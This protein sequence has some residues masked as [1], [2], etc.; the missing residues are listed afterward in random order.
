MRSA[1]LLLALAVACGDDSAPGSDASTDVPGTDADGTDADGVDAPGTDAPGCGTDQE[2]ADV[3]IPMRDGAMLAAFIRR[4]VDAD[5][6][7]PTVLIQ[8]PYDKEN[9]RALW[10]ES[11]G[12]NPLFDSTDYAFVVLDWRGRFG[13]SDAEADSMKLGTDGF[14]A[15]E[16]ITAQTWSDGSVGTFG[17]SALCRVQ[18]RTA[19]EQPPGLRAAVPIF[20]PRREEYEQYFPGGVLR[21]EYL[22]S[23]GI[24]FGTVSTLLETHPTHDAL[25][26]SVENTTDPTARIQTPMLLISGWWDLSPAIQLADFA[27]LRER[28]PAGDDHRLLIGPWSHFATNAESEGI[29][30]DY[31]DEERLYFD[32]EQQIQSDTLAFFDLHLRGLE[33]AASA[34]PTVRWT[35]GASETEESGDAWPPSDSISRE[36]YL[37]SGDTL[38]TG[39]PDGPPIDV[40]F[41]CDPADPS[42]TI[43]GMGLRFDLL[44]GPTD[45]AEVIARDDAVTF[46]T[47]PVSETLR[48]RGR[49]VANLRVKTTGA[50]TDF[51]VRI[52]D[53]RPDGTWLWIGEG[54]RRLSLRDDFGTRSEVVA[55]TEYD[56]PVELANHL[57]Y[58]LPVGHALGLIVS[59]SN[60]PRFDVNPND[61]TDFL[62][63]G[64]GV[65][66]TNT[67]V[68]D[69][70]SRLT[71][72]VAP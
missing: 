1:L 26:R 51:A 63:D 33:S 59:S 32:H 38:D 6:A 43:G 39:E 21:R 41:P 37:G 19:E 53:V 69:G 60:F 47:T 46:A 40:D 22:Q 71:V 17:P 48:I 64:S 50:D 8:T 65:A 42:P 66:V 16:W 20:C 72:P 62:E 30:R 68:T 4:P 7:L 58:D 36:Y 54:I 14:D 18:Y 49:I 67:V 12:A 52:A 5:C 55:G 56:V 70:V 23:L 2:F 27:D 11:S 13:S 24:L 15:I 31:T 28:S 10:F 29:G 44:H 35:T 45:Q 34:W 25:W 61:G 57:A 9:A 3:Q